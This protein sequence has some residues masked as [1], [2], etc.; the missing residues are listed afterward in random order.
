VLRENR[1]L[2]VVVSF[3]VTS[4]KFAS[5]TKSRACSFHKSTPCTLAT[6]YL[7]QEETKFSDTHNWTRCQLT[8]EL[9]IP[10]HPVLV[11]KPRYTTL[12]D[13]SVGR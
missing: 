5:P 7:W 1:R 4:F 10:F 3:L 13:G 8:C 12:Y 2:V 9:G 11:K 6:I